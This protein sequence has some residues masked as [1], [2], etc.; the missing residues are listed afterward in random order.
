MLVR[1]IGTPMSSIDA[2]LDH[3]AD[4]REEDRPN[5]KARAGSP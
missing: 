5:T 1:H 4:L 2:I 3:A